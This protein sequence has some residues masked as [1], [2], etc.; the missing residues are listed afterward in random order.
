MS[1]HRIKIRKLYKELNNRYTYKQY[2][3]ITR[4]YQ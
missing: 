4:G 2:K 1:K 3:V